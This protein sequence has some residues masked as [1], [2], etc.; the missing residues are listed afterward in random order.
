MTSVPLT[1]DSPQKVVRPPAPLPK[2]ILDDLQD[3]NTIMQNQSHGIT[4]TVTHDPAG[5]QAV[6]NKAEGTTLGDVGDFFLR[7]GAFLL[8]AP[9]YAAAFAICGAGSVV[10]FAMILPLAAAG[11]LGGAA[12]GGIIGALVGLGMGNVSMGAEAGAASGGIGFGWLG[13]TPGLLFEALTD[14]PK[15]LIYLTAGKLGAGMVAFAL[16]GERDS[17]RYQKLEDAL[18][19]ASFGIWDTLPKGPEG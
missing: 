17:A 13:A 18:S 9:L 7:A 1:P 10:S 3:L 16:E 15:G 11:A 4:V 14:I 5:L 19:T 12:V 6:T 2:N 8:G